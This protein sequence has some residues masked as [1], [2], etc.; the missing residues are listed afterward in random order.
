V[1][2][3]KIE[4]EAVR[5]KKGTKKWIIEISSKSNLCPEHLIAP[6]ASE[7]FPCTSW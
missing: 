4:K 2:T 7:A 1:C 3:R 6:A 5:R